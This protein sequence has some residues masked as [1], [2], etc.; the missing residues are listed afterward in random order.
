MAAKK[1]SQEE[2]VAQFN[3]LRQEQRQL[4][5]KLSELNMDLNEHK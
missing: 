4:A 2:I 3:K 5:N 1:L